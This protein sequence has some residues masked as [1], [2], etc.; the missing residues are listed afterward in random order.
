MRKS[1]LL[2]FQTDWSQTIQ[3]R[4]HGQHFATATYHGAD[5]MVHNISELKVRL[6]SLIVK[7]LN[8]VRLILKTTYS[9]LK[10]SLRVN[11]GI[12]SI[13]RFEKKISSKRRLQFFSL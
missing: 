10:L 9:V 5:V 2:V 6:S 12:K 13:H 1:V 7:E 3:R 8:S 11:G 4:F